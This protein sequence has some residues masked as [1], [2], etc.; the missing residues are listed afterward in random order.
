[1]TQDQQPPQGS[2]PAQG[3]HPS[4]GSHPAAAPPSGAPP[5]GPPAAP[6]PAPESGPVLFL[7]AFFKRNIVAGVL[8]LT[9]LVATFYFLLV[10]IRWIDRILLL[11]P[12]QWRPETL[13]GVQ[14]P[15]LGVFVL[16]AVLIVT[17]VLVRNF[18]GKKLVELGDYILYHIPVVSPL[19]RAVKQLVETIFSGAARDFKRVVLIEYPRK[20]VYT[21]AFVTGVSTG[22]I[23]EKT[24]QKVLNVFVP[25][26]PNP[27]SGFYLIVPEDDVVPL[28]MGVEDAFRLLMSGGILSPE[29]R[30]H[31][32][33][34][35][36]R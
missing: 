25:T 31:K 24:H 3:A 16:I 22:E 26:T 30:K 1:M 9:P 23:Q 5:A 28:E 20:G 6:G 19:Y 35:P 33:A 14:I 15:G 7:K 18:L 2:Q 11:I 4:Q 10:L 12:V 13:L 34:P 17:G 32:T 8:F 36:R 29:K 27:T 21:L